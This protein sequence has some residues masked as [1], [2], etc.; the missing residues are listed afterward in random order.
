MTPKAQTL[1][2]LGL[3]ARGG[4]N[5]QITGLAVDS[6]QVRNG[7]LFA[8]IPGS[9]IHGATFVETAWLVSVR[10]CR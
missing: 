8:A 10:D 5:P 3:T 2:S 6:R 7:F 9:R 1:S 4:A